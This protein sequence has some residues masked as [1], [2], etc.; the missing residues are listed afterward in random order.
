MRVFEA[1]NS[2][3]DRNEHI[4]PDLGNAT[5]SFSPNDTQTKLSKQQQIKYADS[6]D[7]IEVEFEPN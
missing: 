5:L 7:L 6:V 1:E 3:K 2:R 4:T